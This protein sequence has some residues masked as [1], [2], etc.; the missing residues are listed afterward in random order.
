MN[1]Y[2]TQKPHRKNTTRLMDETEARAS[3]ISFM[4]LFKFSHEHFPLFPVHN[5]NK[6]LGNVPG[7]S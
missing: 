7:R 1:Y 4:M 6:L 2:Q 5:V 3:G